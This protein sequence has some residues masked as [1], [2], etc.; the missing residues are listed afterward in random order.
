MP[1]IFRDVAEFNSQ[2]IGLPQLERPGSLDPHRKAHAVDHLTEEL[3]E[4]AQ[5]R[6][7]EDEVDALVD[8]IYVAAGRLY[9]MGTDAEAH[10][11]EVH[12]A[13]MK[14]VRGEKSTRPNSLGYDAVKPDGWLEPNHRGVIDILGFGRPGHLFKTKRGTVYETKERAPR[15]EPE[16]LHASL[17]EMSPIPASH[18]IEHRRRPR[19]LVLGHARHG[20]DT[21]AEL[22]RD[23]YGVKF[24]SSSM[25]CAERVMMPYFGYHSVPYASVEECY[26]DRVNHRDTWFQ[27]ISLYNADDPT[28]LAREM[29]E[30]GNDMYV[31]MRSDRE[32]QQARHLFDHVVW[33]DARGRGVPLEPST[34]FDIRVGKDEAHYISNNGTLSQLRCAVES[35]ASIV[36]LEPKP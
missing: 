30:V 4:Y 28:R 26:E 19:I 35:F 21:V 36:G 17:R 16:V 1:D 13:N 10:W 24:S 9:E 29:L 32:F 3:D 31:G 20:K 23:L 25:F 15:F 14:R 6:T 2:I 7:V 8:L 34:S 12:G 22:L 5:A 33:V 27:Q 11:D 18:Q